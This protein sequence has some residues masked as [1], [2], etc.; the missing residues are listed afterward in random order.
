MAVTK[1]ILVVIY[2]GIAITDIDRWVVTKAI[3]VS[4]AQSIFTRANIFIV[5]DT[6]LVL[7]NIRIAGANIDR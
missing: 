4:I 1:F 7:I 5:T 2:I 6:I 3:L